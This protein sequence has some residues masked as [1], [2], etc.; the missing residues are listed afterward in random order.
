MERYEVLEHTADLLIRGKGSTLEECYGNLAYGMFDQT[1]DLS[2]VRPLERRHVEVEGED[3]EDAL[4]SFLSELL[5]IEN[6]EDL[7]LCQFSVSIDG[8]RIVCDCAGERLDRSR[9]HIRGE[10]KAVTFHMMDINAAVPQ[11]TVLFDV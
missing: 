3:A 6:Y 9:M 8:N 2:S 1:V 5:F 11:V 7:I 10:I 4:Y